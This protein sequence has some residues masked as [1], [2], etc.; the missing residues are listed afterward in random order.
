[1]L[2]APAQRGVKEQASVGLNDNTGRREV[3]GIYSL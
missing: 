2:L 3:F 1:M